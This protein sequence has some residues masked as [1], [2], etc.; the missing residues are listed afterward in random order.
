MKKSDYSLPDQYVESDP[1]CVL[2]SAWLVEFYS[3]VSRVPASREKEPE[4]DNF[5]WS[6]NQF[7]SIN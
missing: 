2:V 6:F 1:T 4:I 7:N 5:S 3:P